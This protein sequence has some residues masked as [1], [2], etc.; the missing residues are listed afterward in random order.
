MIFGISSSS[1]IEWYITKN[2]SRKLLF[3][4][5]SKT[6]S[7]ISSFVFCKRYGHLE[8]DEAETFT[9]D[10]YWGTLLMIITPT[11]EIASRL[12]YGFSGKLGFWTKTL[13]FFMH[14]ALQKKTKVIFGI[15]SSSCIEWYITK[16]FSRK[17]LFSYISKTLSKISSSVFFE[18]CGHLE[19]DQAETF[20]E[21]AYWGTLLMIIAPTLEIASRLC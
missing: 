20:T 17:L 12:C 10:A 7:K 5:I 6:L 9:E 3:S 11:L 14:T 13:I 8:S 1:C 15:S 2:F 18:R 19:F 4:Y 16:K 21:D